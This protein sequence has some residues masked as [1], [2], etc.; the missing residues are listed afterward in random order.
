[1]A[2]PAGKTAATGLVQG[3]KMALGRSTATGVGAAM[4]AP[5]GTKTEAGLKAGGMAL[6]WEAALGGLPHLGLKKGTSINARSGAL[7]GREKEFQK[8][9]DAPMKAYEALKDS[10]PAEAWMHVPSISKTPITFKEASERLSKLKGVD[11]EAARN[12][13]FSELQ[14]GGSSLLAGPKLSPPVKAAEALSGSPGKSPYTAE[15]FKTRVPEARFDP[16]S[17]EAERFAKQAVGT[18]KSPG[19]RTGVDVGASQEGPGDVPVGVW[20]FVGLKELATGAG[21]GLMGVARRYIH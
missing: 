9:T 16:P 6:A 7:A 4:D 20:P 1:V 14:R 8:A 12:E 10:V 2:G 18:L 15:G 19:V 3:A 13:I 21:G 11:W 5:M 17:T